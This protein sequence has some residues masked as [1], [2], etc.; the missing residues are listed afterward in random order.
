MLY[1]IL[2]LFISFIISK[3]II[4]Y[5]HKHN[6]FIDCSQSSKPQRF[7]DNSTPRSGGLG[8]VSGFLLFLLSV[9]GLK[10][11]IP[12]LLALL[13]GI[14]EDFNSFLT[15]VQRLILQTIAAVTAMWLLNAVIVYLGLGVYLPIVLG[16]IFTAF[17]IV[18]LMNAINIIDGFNG[19]ASGVVILITLS[20]GYVAHIQ[21]NSDVL[22]IIYIVLGSTVGFFIIN[23]PKGK[24][25][26][27]DGGA[28]LL[29][30]ITAILGIFLASKY[31]EVSPWYVLSV[32]IYPVWEVAFSIIRK[33]S[34]GKSPLLPDKFHFHMLVY[35]QI[36]Q[37][38][39][40]T[41][42]FILILVAPFIFYST[43][44]A[45]N[46]KLNI[47]VILTFIACYTLLY[48]AMLY[49]DRKD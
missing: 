49:K 40:L 9:F 14:F 20:F 46:S 10:L 35:R 18:G 42:I 33:L 27:G 23:F 7:H 17:I 45:H 22:N 21:H 3:F 43:I 31:N 29:G 37:N 11:F 16:Y 30:F 41:A 32:L 5:S 15:P 34:I 19:L 47:G 6:I 4:H 2:A 39:P 48:F 44:N 36:T 8:I 12:T 1:F 28:Y 13:S 26:L 38:N 24:I 25:F